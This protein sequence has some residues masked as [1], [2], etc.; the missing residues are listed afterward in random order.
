MTQT[1]LAARIILTAVLSAIAAGSLLAQPLPTATPD[2]QGFS[3]ER[4]ARVHAMLQRQVEDGSYAGAISLVCR[5]GRIVDA[6]AFGYRDLDAKLPMERD[7]IVRI[8]S[9]TKVVTSV[10]ALILLEEG[11]IALDDPVSKYLPALQNPKV[12]AGERAGKRTLV[13]A[14]KPITIKQLLT[15]TSGFIYGF[16]SSPL[17]KLYQNAKLYE[18]GSTTEFVAG[19]AKL[20]LAFQPGERFAYGFNTDVIG[21]VVEVVSGMGLDRFIE[22]RIARPLKMADTGFDVPDGKRGRI[23]RIHQKDKEKRLKPI[24]AFAGVWAEPGRGFPAGGAGLFSTIDDYSRFAQMLANG[25]ELD[26]VR[27]LGRKTVEFMM[28]NHLNNLTPPTTESNPSD[29]FG[30]GGAVRIDLAK[31]SRPGSV[32]EFGWSG[33]ATT[34][35]SIDPVEHT[36]ML[37]FAQHAPFNEH[38]LF[39]HFATLVYASLN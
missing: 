15:H 18:L 9:M 38:D 12:W 25:G 39:R 24:E 16:G 30:L 37:L 14:T 13:K 36:V 4:L 8:Y 33:A 32:G 23:A 3:S 27:I 11:R 35:F 2:S 21:A 5:N 31:G 28:V 17:D 20:P 10:A 26:G 34:T 6:R 7:T 22:E 29:G 1:T 19:L